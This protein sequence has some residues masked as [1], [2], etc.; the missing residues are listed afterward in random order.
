MK[1]NFLLKEQREANKKKFT[2]PTYR[3]V[4]GSVTDLVGDKS[5]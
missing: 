5:P 3:A 2:N 4:F 1:K